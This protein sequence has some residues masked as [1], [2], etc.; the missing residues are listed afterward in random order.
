LVD[1]PCVDV[2]EDLT[3]GPGIGR[4]VHGLTDHELGLIAGDLLVTVEIVVHEVH[5]HI[6]GVDS[7]TFLLHRFG[8]DAVL[9]AGDIV[10]SARVAHGEESL[11]VFLSSL[12]PVKFS[13]RSSKTCEAS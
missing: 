9:L 8:A 11:I 4:G 3:E 6:N 10:I 12:C 13:R 5:V 7:G 1:G 2:V